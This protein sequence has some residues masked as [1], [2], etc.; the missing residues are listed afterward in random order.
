MS[1][2]SSPT[3]FDLGVTDFSIRHGNAIKFRSGEGLLVKFNGLG[4]V[5]TNQI[6]RGVFVTVRDGFGLAHN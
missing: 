6:G 4:R 1:T 2:I 3:N 5:A